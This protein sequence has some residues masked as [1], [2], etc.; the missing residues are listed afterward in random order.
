MATTLK[1]LNSFT[2]DSNGIETIGKQGAIADALTDKY[3]L[4]TSPTSLTISGTSKY[5]KGSLAT[6][7]V[8]LLY[9]SSVDFPATFDY[10]F[11]WA[12]QD[13]YIQVIGSSTN[14]VYKVGAQVPFVIPG[15]GKILAAANG[16]AITGGSE[17]SVAAVTK[18]YL[19][20]YSGTT[21]N[22]VFAAIN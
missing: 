2:L 15:Y 22:F 20:N 3:S 16:T 13:S 8:N 7:T 19:G 17:P 4:A 10:G 1:I 14:A 5:M 11:L 9:D 6:A 12:D 21:L 18:I